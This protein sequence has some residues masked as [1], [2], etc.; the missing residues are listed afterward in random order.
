KSVSP[1]MVQENGLGNQTVTYTFTV[2]NT[3]AASTDPVTIQS[4][5]DNVLGALAGSGTC[6]VGTTLA[7]GA[8][9][10]FTVT[11]TVPSQADG[12]TLTNT[13]TATGKD[14]EN[15]STSASASATVYYV[16]A[17]IT[18]SPAGT[19]VNPID[20]GNGSSAHT[21]TANVTTT[22]PAGSG[23]TVTNGNITITA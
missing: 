6:G 4:L 17:S 16:G 11:T 8:S 15:N 20:P 18:L 23:I 13:F 21:F 14:D 10:T 7:P 3:S 1:K 2:T 19:A 22:V 12:T 9:C 5:S